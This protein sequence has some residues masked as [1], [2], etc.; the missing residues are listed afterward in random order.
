MSNFIKYSRLML[1]CS[2]SEV[3]RA[4]TYKKVRAVD[5]LRKVEAV[6]SACNQESEIFTMRILDKK[7][8]G[9][10]FSS[11]SSRFWLASMFSLLR[12]NQIQDNSAAWQAVE[13]Y[14]ASYYAA[15]FMI[16]MSGRSISQLDKGVIDQIKKS[17]LTGEDFHANSGL[18]LINYRDFD[19]VTF[20]PLP[21]GGGSHKQA[22]MAWEDMV[23][24]L[25]SLT[26]VDIEE[27]ARQ[28]ISLSEHKRSICPES[29]MKPS[30]IRSEINYQFKG[31]LW[32]FEERS[33]IISPKIRGVI[34]GDIRGSDL[35]LGRPETLIKTSRY[36]VYLAYAMMEA[37]RIRYPASI[38][39]KYHN[40]NKGYYGNLIEKIKQSMDN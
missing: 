29:H 16:R 12:A 13:A 34:S 24:D 10:Y 23:A 40:L 32:P 1:S 33:N 37:A 17:N 11:E 5:N 38:L 19:N 28:S 8:M 4:V 7:A 6:L 31:N 2:V 26:G 35:N 30:D 14:Y 3:L 22:W 39:S 18:Y 27:Y 15:Q 9:Q 20:K 36:I 21:R 25:I